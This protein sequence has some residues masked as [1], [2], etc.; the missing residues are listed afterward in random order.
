MLQS[1]KIQNVA[2]IEEVEIDFTG[3]LNV[4]TGETGAGKSILVDSL[5]VILGARVSSD[6]IRQ[7][8]DEL[9]VEGIFSM[10]LTHPL[11]SELMEL[12][13][14]IEEDGS[15]ILTRKVARNGK[16]S[17][18]VNGW[19]VPVGTLKNIGR[20]L[21]QVHAQH[22]T[23]EIFSASFA[24]DTLDQVDEGLGKVKESYQKEYSSWKGLIEDLAEMEQ[25]E[26]GKKE[27]LE[28][29]SWQ[30]QEI[31]EVELNVEEEQELEN[32]ILAASNVG[33]ISEGLAKSYSLLNQEDSS[34]LANLSRSIKEIS[35]ASRYDTHLVEIE[36]D[37]QN[38]FYQLEELTLSLRGRLDHIEFDPFEFEKKQQRMEKIHQLKKKYSMEVPELIQK[39]SALLTEK[40]EL[41]NSQFLKDDL[42]KKIKAALIRVEEKGREL[43]KKR[44]QV[45]KKW[46]KQV[47]DSIREMSMPEAR[48]EVRVSEQ[49][50]WSSQ[51]RDE[52]DFLF[53]ANVG[54]GV[55]SL[56]KVASG[57][58]LSR[59]ALAIQAVANF[60]TTGKTLI[61]D[62][63]DTGI[64]GR[65]AL[66]VGE[67]MKS[68]AQKNQILAITHLPQ[69]AVCAETQFCIEK[70][71][72][73]GKTYTEVSCLSE[74]ERIDEIARMLSGEA[75]Q[76]LARKMAEDMLQLGKK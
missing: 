27:R 54:Q 43:S 36:K 53:S 67:K 12:D 21:I 37:F 50:E 15:L 63:I 39:L 73:N 61:F 59:V 51:G 3:G 46:Q 44:S 64:G 22:D 2:L 52:V 47:E 30:V 68:L 66:A 23:L 70:V 6:L 62:E 10:P 25:K 13:I 42:E 29:I 18:R 65:T 69:I 45:A 31:S 24:L 72:K 55:Q 38:L 71:V 28:L 20:Q 14:P 41:E 40:E 5:G 19:Q 58:E 1:L 75:N 33:K 60:K 32:Y 17:V 35:T 11:V 57:G 7:D 9:R 26:E 16:N 49:S 76:E 48:F 56:K 4:L 74:T 34:V 8:M